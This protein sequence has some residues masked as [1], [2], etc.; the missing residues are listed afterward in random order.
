MASNAVRRSTCGL[1]LS[2]AVAA[3]AADTSPPNASLIEKSLRDAMEIPAGTP[4][5]FQGEDGKSMSADAFAAQMTA[6][7]FSAVA[8]KS[9]PGKMILRLQRE[10]PK[11]PEPGPSHLPAMDLVDLSGRR[12]RNADLAGRP[13]L[14]SFYF[15]TCVPCIKEVPALNAYRKAHP[16]LNYLAVTFDSAAEAKQFVADRGLGWPVVANARSFIDAASVRGFPT[17]MLVGP[18]GRILGRESGLTFNVSEAIPGM[19]ALEKFV[20]GLLK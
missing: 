14:L 8:D 11:A 20:M 18:D 4:V 9:Q 17:Y 5:E 19:A 1:L 16:D 7:G 2:V 12:V 6:P 3:F 15:A 10:K 13:T